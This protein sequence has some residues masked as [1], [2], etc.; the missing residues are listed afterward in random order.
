MAM[1][2]AVRSWLSENSIPQSTWSA[3]LKKLGRSYT[4]YGHMLLLP[5]NAL[6][7]PEWDAIDSHLQPTSLDSLCALLCKHLKITNIAVNR[8][9]P[10]RQENS[11]DE[12]ILRAPTNFTP[13]YGDFGPETCDLPPTIEDFDAAFWVT[14]RQNGISQIWAPRWTMFSRGNISEKARLLTLPSVVKMV[15]EGRRS[16]WGCAAVDL[17]CGIGYF[18]FSYVKAGVTKVLGWDLNPW[19]V[20]GLRRGA[21]ANKWDV[22]VYEDGK[23]ELNHVAGGEARLLIFN[24]SNK[25]APERIAS[26][27]E[28]LPPIR[29]IN[30][31]ML[32]SS[33]ASLQLASTILDA[34]YDGWVHVHENF[35]VEEIE[36]KAEG[37]RQ[38]LQSLLAEQRKGEVRVGVEHINRLKS[39]APGVMHCVIDILVEAS[40]PT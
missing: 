21:R 40:N 3:L 24:E 37:T 1:E 2:R 20:E 39:Y 14:A 11:Q 34:R 17:Y 26:M 23:T 6:S 25:H 27:K 19:S 8:P 13:I 31:G 16:G 36:L 32:P 4:I 7:G 29:H 12:N 15:D 38:E 10:P 18:S 35:L 22:T 28:E 30:C 33:R 9:I 5:A